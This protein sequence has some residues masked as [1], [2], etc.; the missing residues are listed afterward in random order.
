MYCKTVLM[1]GAIC[2]STLSLP[3]QK[4]KQPVDYV[5][6]F[7]GVLDGT[8][9][10]N[11][12]IG[13]QLPFGS[14]S[15]APQTIN[16]GNDGYSPDYPIRGFGQLHPS[17]TGWGTNGQIFLSPQTGLAVGETAHDSPKSN[18]KAT[19]YEYAVRLDRYNI[20]VAFTPARHSTIYRFTFPASDSSHI[21]IDITHNLP[22]DIRP[23]IGGE[24]T[25]G[26]VSI[27]GQLITGYGMYKGGWG[28]GTYKVYFAAAVS[29]SP[30]ATGTWLNG[31]VNMSSTAAQLL[32]KND[33]VGAILRFSTHEQETVYLKIAVSFKSVAQATSWLQQ[34]IPDFNYNAIRQKARTAWNTLLKKIEVTGGTEKDKTLFY[35]ALYH[36]NLMPRDRTN[37]LPGFGKD[38]PVWDDHYA[39]WD[40]WRTVY[41]LHMLLS[42]EMVAGTVNSFIA[43]FQ[44]NGVVRDSYVNGHEMNNEQGGNNVDNI[45]ADAYLKHIP[46]I[47]WEAAYRILK[48]DAD[49]Q[50]LGAFAW[51]PQDSALNTYCSKGWIPAGIMNCS[52]SLEYAYNDH[53]AALV[54]KG[55]GK[56]AD[57]KHYLWRSHQ[58]T[59]MWDPQAAS[60][61]WKGFI[62]PRQPDGT[63]VDIDLK[64]YP[65]SWKNYFYEG[66]SWTYSWFM[67][68]DFDTL[69]QLNGG[70]TTFV[71]K[72]EYGFAHH[73]IDYGNEPAFLAVQGFHYGNRPDRASYWIRQLM[74]ERFTDKGVPGNDDSGAM[75]AWYV[76]AAM[77]FFPNAGQDIYYL[78]GPVFTKIV[79]HLGNGKMLTIQAPK[80][81][82]KNIFVH[83]IT[84]NGKKH[85]GTIISY[86]DIEKGGTILF[87]MASAQ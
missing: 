47:N 78:N 61:G 80:A 74:K 67:P 10:S 6:N 46:G 43:R 82:E 41:P 51:R 48:Y 60:D 25:E 1:A 13:P 65:G 85:T 3:A 15:P 57:Y 7:I 55:L 77:G 56:T 72:L 29:K 31:A 38:V 22:M 21:L 35:T 37:D 28:D 79:L 62:V 59:N 54:A 26:N 66:S 20:A 34:E 8:D 17:G 71:Q 49:S 84:I 53:C 32:K 63:F 40:T 39:V 69:V 81:S 11:C 76:F 16:G 18:E 9:A 45:I 83:G 52:M 42:P 4:I 5:N 73:L 36:A 87:D 58:W 70:K 44:K 86:K 33:R 64:K 23:V 68:H 24:V 75:S 19:P 12:V 30:S 27:H 50:R 14:V 2:F